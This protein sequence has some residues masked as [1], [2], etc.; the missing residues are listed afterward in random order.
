M[1]IPQSSIDTLFRMPMSAI[2]HLDLLCF[3]PEWKEKVSKTF[4]T[5]FKDSLSFKKNLVSLALAVYKKVRSKN[6]RPCISLFCLIKLNTISSVYLYFHLGF[7]FHIN[8]IEPFKYTWYWA[9][10]HFNKIFWIFHKILRWDIVPI[11]WFVC[12]F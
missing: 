11:I 12:N 8:A 6:V 9:L 5:F 1:F 3:K 2:S 7:Y 10:K 4:I